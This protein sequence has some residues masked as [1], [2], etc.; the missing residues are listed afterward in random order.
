MYTTNKVNKCY[1]MCIFMKLHIPR[2]VVVLETILTLIM[3]NGYIHVHR[4]VIKTHYSFSSKTR[5]C[6]RR[7]FVHEHAL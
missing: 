2:I 5:E 4:D 6:C 1:V 7:Y 3:T